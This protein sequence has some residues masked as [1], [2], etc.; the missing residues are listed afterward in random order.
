MQLKEFNFWELATMEL[1]N[2]IELNGIFKQYEA[3]S[4]LIEEGTFLDKIYITRSGK[5][6][7]ISQDFGQLYN[8]DRS[9]VDSNGLIFGEMSC[10][11]KKASSASVIAQGA[12]QAY[13]IEWN[14][15]LHLQD[16]D[17]ALAGEFFKLMAIKIALQITD[18]NELIYTS[19]LTLNEPPFR[20]ALSFFAEISQES[21][22]TIANLSTLRRI[23]P[24]EFLI[25]E[26]DLID[27]LFI[28]LAGDAQIFKNKS[29]AP[30]RSI[31]QSTRGEIIGEITFLV[32]K[33][34]KAS[35][36]IAS[37]MGMDLLE[38]SQ[39]DLHHEINQNAI[40]C[41]DFY[42]GLNNMLS[43]RSRDQV[44]MASKATAKDDELSLGNEEI[45]L[46]MLKQVDV[47]GKKFDWL[48]N[49]FKTN[50]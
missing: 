35:V 25:N 24:R 6:K 33:I 38:I 4:I 8:T 31:G 11:E 47:A 44:V 12:G 48:C 19:M 40:F 32:D 23:K 17:Q 45:D 36:S 2:W 30:P 42:R 28:I 16:S 26:D 37:K 10:L 43:Q 7:V 13:S 50:K 20:K 5:I 15:I 34:D 18:Q 27:K 21:M 3:N 9:N 41:M 29:N 1:K 49:Q 46:K 14:K 22:I 39:N